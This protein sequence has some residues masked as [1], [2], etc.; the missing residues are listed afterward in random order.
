MI[1][2]VNTT[3]ETFCKQRLF[4]RIL[5]MEKVLVTIY[6]APPTSNEHR[7]VQVNVSTSSNITFINGT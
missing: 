6:A 3:L 4:Q 7:L 2:L 1:F 5:Q